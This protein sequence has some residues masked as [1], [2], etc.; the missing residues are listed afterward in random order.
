MPETPV[1]GVLLSLVQQRYNL[2][3]PEA[4]P[5]WASGQAIEDACQ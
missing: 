3:M 1:A 2:W 4:C 5:P